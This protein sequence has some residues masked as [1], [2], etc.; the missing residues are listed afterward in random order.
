[1]LV[2]DLIRRKSWVAKRAWIAAFERRNVEAASALHATSKVEA[3]DIKRLRLRHQRMIIVAN[4]TEVPELGVCNDVAHDG[5]RRPTVLFLGR[6][7]WKKGLDRLITAMAQLPDADLIVAGDDE[8]Y[9]A[10]LELLTA[11]LGLG[12]RV[13]FIGALHGP[14]KWMMFKS[15][16]VLVLPSYSENFGNV[17]LEAMAV[18]C[19]VVVT[20]EVGLA[21]VVG[22]SGAGL[23][24]P[25]D[26]Q[27]LAR[28]LSSIFTNPDTARAMGEVGRK[29]VAERFTWEV[30]AVQM[31]HAYQQIMGDRNGVQ[32]NVR[33]SSARR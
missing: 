23:V 6:V 7:N 3:E 11:R 25:G 31:E 33:S 13:R 9:R 12:A 8:G 30:V 17:V 2:A 5:R 1:M 16:Q 18:G 20:P 26:P 28:A 19:P 22:E 29:L 24:S 15:A 14:E 27:A 32:R 10:R 4:G 21:S